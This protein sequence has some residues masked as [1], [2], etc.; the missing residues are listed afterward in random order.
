MKDKYKKYIDY[1][2]SDIQAPYFKNMENQ[3]GLRPDE[4]RLVL[5]KVYKQPVTIE[6]DYVYDNQGNKIYYE[7]CNGFWVKYVYDNQ[8]NEIYYE[9]SNGHIEDNR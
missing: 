7:T 9:D 3:Y 2:V 8:G 4:Y 1:I 5:S 6:G